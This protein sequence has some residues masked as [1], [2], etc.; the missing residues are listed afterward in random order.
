MF[1][2][3]KSWSQVPSGSSA[4]GAVSTS[5]LSPQQV[6]ISTWESLKQALPTAGTDSGSQSVC[7]GP[8]CGRL[9][10][11]IWEI[12]RNEN[13]PTCPRPTRQKLGVRP[14][15]GVLTHPPDDHELENHR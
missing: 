11:I 13:V 5:R 3:L 4:E 12:V 1:A 9:L 8:K 2:F 6:R 14:A 10:S 15:S 7:P